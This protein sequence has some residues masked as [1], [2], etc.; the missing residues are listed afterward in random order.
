[1]QPLGILGGVYRVGTLSA[2]LNN[3]LGPDVD[4]YCSLAFHSG[5]TCCKRAMLA[6]PKEGQL[7]TLKSFSFLHI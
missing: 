5:V 7:S 1:M 3:R 2:V 6:T 4:I